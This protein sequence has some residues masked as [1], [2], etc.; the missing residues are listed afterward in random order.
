MAAAAQLPSASDGIRCGAA[1]A[2][3]DRG[4]GHSRASRKRLLEDSVDRRRSFT[5][6]ASKG[7]LLD[8][9][10]AP[11]SLSLHF[12][13]EVLSEELLLAQRHALRRKR[14]RDALRERF[15]GPK[16]RWPLLELQRP[17]PRGVPRIRRWSSECSI[18]TGSTGGDARRVSPEPRA[19]LPVD[20]CG[21]LR[22]E[23]PRSRRQCR[24]SRPAAARGERWALALAVSRNE[25]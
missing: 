9:R 2:L 5:S 21:P 24:A 17:R 22:P 6:E 8:R 16:H 12:F 13:A 18:T 20:L 14:S 25:E 4:R 7:L 15:G 3:A 1:A 19:A 11:T 10:S 23:L